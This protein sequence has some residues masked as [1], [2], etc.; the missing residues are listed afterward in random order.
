MKDNLKVINIID[1]E[2]ICGQMKIIKK[3]NWQIIVCM[4]KVNIYNQMEEFR[5][6]NGK[7]INF[8]I[9][10]FIS[11]IILYYLFGFMI[12]SSILNIKIFYQYQI[13]LL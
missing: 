8:K 4:D 11:I 1:I 6:V 7:I 10:I 9:E 12:C 13:I 3:E 2:D 5:K